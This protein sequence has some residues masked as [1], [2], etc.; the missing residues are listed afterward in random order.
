MG[1]VIDIRSRR[2]DKPTPLLSKA[3]L[4]IVLKEITDLLMESERARASIPSLG[5]T[6]LREKAAISSHELLMKAH[7][8]ADKNGLRIW[9]EES[10]G[11]K[12]YKVG[13]KQQGK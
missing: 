12:D 13:P 10:P 3:A 5:T 2:G 8:V 7:E 9:V 1:E 6:Y 11:S 4:E